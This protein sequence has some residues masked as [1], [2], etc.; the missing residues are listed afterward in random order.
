MTD[1]AFVA[2]SLADLA[3]LAAAVSATAQVR[4]EAG[5]AKV[6]TATQSTASDTKAS[7]AA[8]TDTKEPSPR[9]AAKPVEPVAVEPPSDNRF[10]VMGTAAVSLG[11][12]MFV[13][14]LGTLALSR[15]KK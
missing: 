6:E 12:L 10:G 7:T 15:K 5:T 14:V 11:G 4:A 13:V 3:L 8:D 9:P 1:P 2:K